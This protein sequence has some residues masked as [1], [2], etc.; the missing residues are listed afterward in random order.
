MANPLSLAAFAGGAIMM[1]VSRRKGSAVVEHTESYPDNDEEYT[2]ALLEHIKG[3]ETHISTVYAEKMALEDQVFQLN[4]KLQSESE[5]RE[6][7]AA[8]LQKEVQSLTEEYNRARAEAIQAWGEVATIRSS[9]EGI[10]QV[11]QEP[12]PKKETKPAEEPAKPPPKVES[13]SSVLDNPKFIEVPASSAG[14][15]QKGAPHAAPVEV[16]PM[17]AVPAQPPPSQTQ[18]FDPMMVQQQMLALKAQ[19]QD[20]AL[21]DAQKQMAILQFQALTKQVTQHMQQ[22]PAQQQ[23]VQQQPAQQQSLQQPV[24]LQVNTKIGT[25][26]SQPDFPLPTENDAGKLLLLNQQQ[27]EA[28]KQQMMINQ[29][30]E[31]AARMMHQQQQMQQMQ[32]QQ[33]Q[34]MQQQQQQQAMMRQATMVPP[35]MQQQ[36]LPPGQCSELSP[37][38]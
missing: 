24:Q 6:K 10:K 15:E 5:R 17:Q 37:S 32:Q 8:P 31:A 3:L 34:Q 26:D 2:K 7:V 12:E 30:N 20:P 22:Q 35:Q 4:Q 33:M 38:T 25:N 29:Q 9:M 21:P 27:N 14:S 23:P 19:L 18:K 1:F 28:I 11:Q 13:F 36:M 16:K